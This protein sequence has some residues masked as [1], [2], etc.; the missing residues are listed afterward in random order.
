MKHRSAVP[1]IGHAH[2]QTKTISRFAKYKENE[3]QEYVSAGK[4]GWVQLDKCIIKNEDGSTVEFTYK[5]SDFSSPVVVR[6]F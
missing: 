2:K 6:C 3:E 4:Y 1:P 5:D